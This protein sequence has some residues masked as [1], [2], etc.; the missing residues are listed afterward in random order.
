MSGD[1]IEIVRSLYRALNERDVET[2]SRLTSA[3]VEWIPDAR[4]GHG[5]VRGR[6]RVIGFHSD[7]AEMFEDLRAELE[8]LHEAPR[9]VLALVRL[10]GLGSGSGAGFDIRIAHLWTLRE[11]VVVRGKAYADRQ[12][13]RRAAGLEAD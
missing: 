11:G 2:I 10:T 9:G 13:G 8:E 3:D 5:P 1:S 7:R 12:Q 4:V 6:E